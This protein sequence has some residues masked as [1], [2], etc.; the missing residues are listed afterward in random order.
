MLIGVLKVREELLEVAYFLL[1]CQDETVLEFDLLFLI[2]GDEVRGHISSIEF[3]AINIFNFVMEC[4]SFLNGDGAMNTDF[5]IEFSEHVTDFAIT[6][7]RN[8]GNIRD[9]L[10][11]SD[12]SGGSFELIG[13][14][15]YCLIDASFYVGWVDSR[16]DFLESLFEDGSS[17]DGGCGG[18]VTSFVVGLIGDTLDKT[19]TDVD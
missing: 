6:V 13:D 18:S 1:N 15:L 9:G 8:G 2:I 16:L 19:G 17:E 12:F 5:L 11:S 10:F 7:S 4:F 14:E 3:E